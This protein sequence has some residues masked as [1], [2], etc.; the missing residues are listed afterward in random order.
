MRTPWL[1]ATIALIAALSYGIGAA[2]TYVSE[3]GTWWQ[4]EVPHYA[5]SFVLEGMVDASKSG[6]SSGSGDEARRIESALDSSEIGEGRRNAI[7]NLIE[8]VVSVDHAPAF[9]HT[10]SYYVAAI[11]DFYSSHPSAQALAVGDV[12]DCLQDHPTFSCEWLAAWA[13]HHSSPPR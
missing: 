13:Q 3:D 5:K 8:A 4:I 7:H 12:L 1:A 10:D 2:T 11:S 6:W 9:S